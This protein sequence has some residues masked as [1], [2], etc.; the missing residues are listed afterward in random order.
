M[1]R[2]VYTAAMGMLA[3]LTKIDT[4]SNNLANVETNGYKSDSPAF[5]TYL[6]RE[7]Y[8]IK[9]EPENRR[10]EVA[11]IGNVEQAI[12]VD[13]VRTLFT[14]GNLEQTNVQTH[15][16]ISGDGFF[17][18]QKNGKTLY[19]RNGEFVIDNERRLVNTQGYYLLDNN[20]QIVRFPENGS[21][22]EKGNVRDANGNLVA[23]VP[24]YSIQNPE[25]VGETLFT[26]QA[27]VID[28][29][30][31]NDIRILQ[32][33]VEKSNVNAVREMVRMIEA[34][35]HYDATSKT[36][37]VHDELLNKLINNVGALR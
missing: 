21:I 26:G 19:T 18:V 20:G 24:I 29:N 9:P 17:A 10:V 35:R 7:I 3:D 31:P 33:F 23:T 1:Y 28:M 15:L 34:H 32:G 36:I 14:Q 12:I 37:A 13:E 27:Q 4:L 6:E 2:G 5:R 16:A 22:D 8:R 11:K 30:T 25:K